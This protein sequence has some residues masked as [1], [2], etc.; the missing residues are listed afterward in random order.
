MLHYHNCLEI[1]L[2]GLKPENLVFERKS[3]TIKVKLQF[4]KYFCSIINECRFDY[5]AE[6]VIKYSTFSGKKLRFVLLGLT[7]K[8][9]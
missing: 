8:Q 1:V 7:S 3:R 4:L 9:L 2:S 5:V 6:G